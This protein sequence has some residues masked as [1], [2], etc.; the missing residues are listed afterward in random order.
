MIDSY[1]FLDSPFTRKTSKVVVCKLA[2]LLTY[3]YQSAN[4]PSSSQ[5][6]VSRRRGV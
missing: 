1:V 6:S 2:G 3:V 4:L 5:P